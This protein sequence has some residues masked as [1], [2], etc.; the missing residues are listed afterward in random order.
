MSVSYFGR[1]EVTAG[2]WAVGGGRWGG[3]DDGWGWGWVR[4][5]HVV[6]SPDS[7]CMTFLL[8]DGG[9]PA[10]QTHTPTHILT[11]TTMHTQTQTVKPKG[12]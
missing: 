10:P 4:V 12:L 7:C 11:Q 9:W 3:E 8:H 5:G 6:F 1:G 2:G